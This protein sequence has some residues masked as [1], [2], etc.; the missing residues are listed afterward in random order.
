MISNANQLANAIAA[1]GGDVPA[2]L[3]SQALFEACTSERHMTDLTL[4]KPKADG[5]KAPDAA[6]R[7]SWREVAA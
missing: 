4:P 6:E 2:G 3:T 5:T 7:A 1:Y